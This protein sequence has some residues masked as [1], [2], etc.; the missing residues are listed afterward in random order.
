M[1][2]FAPIWRWPI[3][4]LNELTAGW[5]QALVV[6]AH[7]DDPEMFCGGTIALLARRG[8][9]VSYVLLTSG[10]KGSDERSLTNQGLVQRR[11]EEQRAAADC[12]GVGEIVFL[13]HPDGELE[14][15][16]EIRREI[17]REIRRFRPQLLLTT[18]PARIYSRGVHHRDHRVAGTLALDAVFPAARNHRYF[19][20]LLSEGWEPHGVKEI[21]IAGAGE[22]DLEFDID[23]VWDTRVAA[24]VCHRSQIGDLDKF[25][26]RMRENREKQQGPMIEKFKRL[27]FG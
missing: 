26:Q 13:H 8:L 14:D 15:K 9:Q 1:V 20:E 24:V 27:K 10:D 21:W 4:D 12:L 3:E 6:M 25:H 18:D 2:H 19:P 22:P 11:E 17:V 5:E 23:A 7:P 16:P